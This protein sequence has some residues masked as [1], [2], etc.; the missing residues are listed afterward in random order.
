[1]IEKIIKA[2]F[3]DIDTKKIK[4]FTREL[5][6]VRELEAKF[7][8]MTLED[9]EKRNLE[10]K[11]SFSHLDF[12]NPEDSKAL[13]QWLE[14]VK[15]EAAA[16]WILTCKLLFGKTFTTES[17][18]EVTWNMLP[19]DVQVIW[20][21]AIH[22]GNVAEMKTWEWKTLVATFPAY[23]N[24]LSGNAV[25]IV[26]VN[27]YLASRD[28]E[29]MWILYTALWLKVWV[30][31]HNQSRDQ[32]K[33]NYASDIIYATNNELGFDYLRDNMET[34]LWILVFMRLSMK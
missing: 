33:L 21:L 7:Q 20:W 13:S 8:D 17:G 28:A 27:D 11:A 18:K 5:K 9:I 16:L 34:K 3:W 15:H 23:L 31:T 29:E 25:H 22:E 4:K 1:M 14:S 32:K 6:H 24:A 2:I 12:Q 10:I 30:I 19:Y 26:T